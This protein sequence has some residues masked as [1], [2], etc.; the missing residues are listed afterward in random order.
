MAGKFPRALCH[1]DCAA[2]GMNDE[3]LSLRVQMRKVQRYIVPVGDITI[4]GNRTHG[5]GLR[6]ATA[7]C[8]NRPS[9]SMLGVS[10]PDQIRNEKIRRRTKVTDIAQRV[11]KLK[12]QWARTGGLLG[13]NPLDPEQINATLV[14][15]QRGGQTTSNE[16]RGRSDHGDDDYL[17]NDIT[18]SGVLEWR[19]KCYFFIA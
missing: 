3:E 15:S 4:C 10:Q 19:L 8:A 11:T 7:H 1:L 12:C 16:S 13:S 9:M 5:L 6:K 18:S 14:G 2:E 17:L